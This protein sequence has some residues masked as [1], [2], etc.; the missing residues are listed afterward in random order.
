MILGVL[1]KLK[2]ITFLRECGSAALSQKSYSIY[3]Y[4]DP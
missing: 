3:F 2:T 4:E 1:T